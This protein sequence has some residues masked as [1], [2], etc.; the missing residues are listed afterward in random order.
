M[1]DGTQSES[2]LTQLTSFSTVPLRVMVSE[3]TDYSAP[4]NENLGAYLF[5][6]FLT[7]DRISVGV[8][9]GY[10]ANDVDQD[11]VNC[12]S[13]SHSY[14]TFFSNMNNLPP[15]IASGG[16]CS[17]CI[18]AHWKTGA[19]MLQSGDYL[20]DNYIFDTEI[21]FGGCGGFGITTSWNNVDGFALGVKY[22]Y[23]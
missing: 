11:F 1:S 2:T 18:M 9:H 5:L 19:K 14:F 7:E 20:P 22:V 4:S 12:D 10:S 17:T 6:G 8:R 23:Y 21:H 15:Q 3:Y 13:K 16:M